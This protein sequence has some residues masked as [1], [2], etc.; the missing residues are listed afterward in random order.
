MSTTT[1]NVNDLKNQLNAAQRHQRQLI[2]EHRDID[3]QI[4]EAMKKVAAEKAQAARQGE[5][6]ARAGSELDV[7][8]LR[9]RK[10]SLP[11][12]IWSQKLTVIGLS[13]TVHENELQQAQADSE[14]A[15]LEFDSARRE[16]ATAEKRHG[17]AFAAADSAGARVNNLKQALRQDARDLQKLE[18][19]PPGA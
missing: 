11:F 16:L 4:A 3:N 13:K 12:E 9:E 10:D 1:I 17:D 2:L 7:Q 6:V 5:D 14:K 15:S 8:S 19:S 18:D